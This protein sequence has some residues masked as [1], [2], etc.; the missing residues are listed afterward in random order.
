MKIVVCGDIHY[1][2]TSSIVRGRGIKYSDRIENCLKSINWFERLALENRCD[3]VVYLGDFFDKNSFKDAS[4]PKSLWGKPNLI[5]FENTKLYAP[6]KLHDY[7]EFYFGDYMQLPPVEKRVCGH[8]SNLDF[9][10]Y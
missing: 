5:Q 6:E 2:K 4:Y 3:I 1:S 10:K 8:H 9:G 7:L